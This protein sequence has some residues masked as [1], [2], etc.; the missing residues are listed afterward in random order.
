MTVESRDVPHEVIVA[1]ILQRL[2]QTLQV[3][4]ASEG[5]P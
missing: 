2:A 1:E 4:A 3:S 5:S